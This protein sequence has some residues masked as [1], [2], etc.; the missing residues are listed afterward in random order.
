MTCRWVT[1]LRGATAVCGMLALGA[2]PDDTTPT[3]DTEGTTSAS[4]DP[5]GSS[6]DAMVCTPGETVPCTCLDLPGV[7]TCQ[8]DG[9]GF[10]GCECEGGDETTT[11]EPSTDSGDESTTGPI[12]CTTDD[13]CPDVNDCEI[14]VCDS[15][16]TCD[17]DFV[18]SGTPCGDSGESQCDNADTC[19]GTGTCES[20]NVID[21]QA[22]TGCAE[23]PC[24]CTA[25]ACGICAQFA[26]TNNFSTAKSIEGWEF[27][28]SW[29]LYTR[30]PQSEMSVAAEFPGQVLGSDGNRVAPFPGS[31]VEAGYALTPPTILPATISFLSWN[32]DEGG[33]ASDNKTI[34]VTTDDGATWNTLADCSVNPAFPFCVYD[35]DQPPGVFTLAEVPVPPALQGQLGRVEF[36]YDTGDACCNFEQGWYIDALNIAT[37]CVCSFDEQCAMYSGE[38]GTGYCTTTG[39]CG[40]LPEANGT[41]CGDALDVDCNAADACLGGYCRDNVANN[42]LDVCD[43]CPGG[44]TCSFCDAGAC[45]DCQSFTDFVGGFSDPFNGPPW[46]VTPIVGVAGWGVYTE[47][48][49][50]EQGAIATVFPNGPVYGTDGNRTP[51]YPGGE[52][53]SSSVVTSIG[54]VP[55]QLT[56]GSWNVDEG[57]GSYD[58]KRIEISVDGGG[59]WAVLEDCQQGSTQPFCDYRDASRAIDDWDAITLD[60]GPW[61]G[62]SAQLRFTYETGDSCCGFERGWYLDL[63]FA[64]C[65]DLPFGQ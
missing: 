15:N 51:P 17:T 63:T 29:G 5:T 53:E 57:G 62:Q 1:W 33:G 25:G 14:G 59:S 34:R 19:N 65:G 9:T 21:G 58:R 45:L 54:T 28:G 12:P 23:E 32:V 22:C 10:A 6:G 18:K 4:T 48:P 31:E 43:D 50:N 30:A 2:C 61:F 35:D 27:T 40:L 3:G 39:E 7:R 11:G 42:G 46:V 41:D 16:G 56:F 64:I 24:T 26:P 13:E 52:S 49:P 20:N 38:C 8:P 37:E 60:T 47:A 44:A 36:A 55:S